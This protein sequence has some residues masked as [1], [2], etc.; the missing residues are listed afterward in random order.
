MVETIPL[1]HF[2]VNSH[3]RFAELVS[4]AQQFDAFRRALRQRLVPIRARFDPPPPFDPSFPRY[5]HGVAFAFGNG[6]VRWVTAG[7][8]VENAD[9]VECR[10]ED[11]DWYRVEVRLPCPGAELAT[12]EHVLTA[13][14]PDRKDKDPIGIQLGLSAANSKEVRAYLPI[15]ALTNLEGTSSVLDVGRVDGILREADSTAWISNL[16]LPPGTP[17]VNVDGAVLLVRVVRGTR[18]YELPPSSLDSC[19]DKSTN[20]NKP[21]PSDP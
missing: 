20:E 19:P 10:N 21:P 7:P 3:K 16:K 11:G 1:E 15:L 8:L 4:N 18:S 13:E 14:N 17:L 6:P 9:Q 12:L 5:V 2:N